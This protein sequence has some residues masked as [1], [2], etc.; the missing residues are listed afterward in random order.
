MTDRL[1]DSYIK[2]GEVRRTVRNWPEDVRTIVDGYRSYTT[3]PHAVQK[4]AIQNGWS[5]RINKKGKGWSF[6]FE[7]LETG[8]RKFLLM[9]DQGTT[10]LTGRVLT[11]EEY[12]K[13]LP[14]EERWGRFEGVAFTQPR[15]ERTLG[16]RGRGK[17]IF[18]GASK[19]YTILYDTLRGDGTYRFGFR[20]VEKT[21]SPVAAYDGEEGRQKLREITGNLIEPLSTVGTRV[22]IVNPIDELIEDIKKGRFLRYIGETWWEI[23]LK[24]GATIKVKAGER[25]NT[26][27]IPEEFDLKEEDWRN[28]K[29]WIKR[30]QRLPA[31]FREIRIKTLHIVYRKDR[32]VPEDIR[33]IAIQRDGMKICTIEP[34]YMPREIAERL[35]GYIN[36][37]ADTEEELLQDE[38]IEHYSYDFR[39]ALPGAIKRFVEDE[40]MKFAREK[41][42]YRVDAREV[43]RQQQRNAERRALTAAN[44][45]ARTLGIGAGPGRTRTGT[46]GERIAKKVRI[47]MEELSLP[48]PADLRVNYGENVSNIKARVVNDSERDIV[49]RFKF[50]LRYYD[51]VFKIFL[52]EDIEV[53]AHSTSQIFGPFEE[54]FTED[55][56]PDKGKYTIVA[57]ITSLMDE[58][59]GAEL[60]YETKSFYLEEDPPMR[61]LFERCE[62]VGFPDEEPVKF[63]MGYSEYGSERGLVLYYN[64]NHPGYTSVSENEEDLAEY[65]LRIA[66]QE[67]CRYDLMQEKSILFTEDQRKDPQEIIKVERKVLGELIYRFRRGEI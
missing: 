42:G 13:D 52:E 43:Q 3:I 10:G 56:Y 22:I 11:P 32:I 17:F 8:E 34:R 45:F 61:G 29:V 24:Y 54:R 19:E 7:L 14:P 35:Y 64:L 53:K 4:D 1:I 21:E 62:A 30:N 18:V 27:T 47:Q 6:T 59:K 25:E 12:E 36:F 5:A 20:T 26:A 40:I 55:K 58:D 15:T 66:A 44:A 63:W 51:K 31:G 39:R 2:E 37:D 16:S 33:G 50:F 60:D 28:G 48:R 38:G 23:I 49:M 67:I 65:I 46:G 41:L 57:K 9:T